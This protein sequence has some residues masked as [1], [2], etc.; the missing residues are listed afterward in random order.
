MMHVIIGENLHDADYVAKYTLGFEQLREKVQEYPP[1]RVAQ[2]TGI[3]ASDIVKL[4]REY[5]TVPSV[6]DSSELRGA[7]LEGGGMATRSYH[8][9]AV[10]YWIVERSR[11]RSADVDQRSGIWASIR[12]S[13]RPDLMQ[14]ALGR[15]ARTINMVE[16][17]MCSTR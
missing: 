9:A 15:E 11:R 2:W 3:A 10:Y 6:G 5:A 7:A 13:K 12:G 14:A 17:E 4:A 8:H 16:W 1:E